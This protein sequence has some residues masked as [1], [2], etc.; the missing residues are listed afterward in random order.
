MDPLYVFEGYTIDEP[1]VIVLALAHNY[2]RL[3]EVPSDETNGI[4]VVDVGD[5]YA[6]G[7]RSPTR[8]PIG[9]ARRAT[10]PIPIPAPRR[11]H[12]F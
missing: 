11:A 1:W 12:W 5:Q 10:T 2:E 7:T 3:K 4:G 6:R 8:W 9:F